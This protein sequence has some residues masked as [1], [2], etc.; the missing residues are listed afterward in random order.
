MN[1]PVNKAAPAVSRKYM[2]AGVIAHAFEHYSEDI[3]EYVVEHMSEKDID[4]MIGIKTKG[5]EGALQMM[6]QTGDLKQKSASKKG[7]VA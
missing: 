5:V 3:W 6:K 2:I 4:A 1:V 7:A